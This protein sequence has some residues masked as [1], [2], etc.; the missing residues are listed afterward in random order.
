M[1][2]KAMGVVTNE[3]RRCGAGRAG[4]RR[5]AGVLLCVLGGATV[6]Q[7]PAASGAPDGTAVSTAR[8]TLAA[9]GGSEALERLRTLRFDFVV[10]RSGKEVARFRHVWDRKNGRYRVE[11]KTQE[12]KQL[13]VLFNLK[14]PSDG[15][16][17]LDRQ[18]L[19]GEER[20]DALERGY[21]RFIN[22]T[23]WLLMPTKMLDPGVR[24]VHEGTEEGPRGTFEIVRLSF[25][26]GVGLTPGDTYWA[27]VSKESGL[28]ERWDFVLQGKQAKDRATFFWQDWREVAGVRLS[29]TKRS[30]DGSTV[31]RFENVAGSA[32]REDAPFNPP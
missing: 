13:L 31:I 5:L 17:W 3:W 26:D 9:M 4:V 25:D 14:D 12:G 30:A 19:T 2:V 18:E 7:P 10:N 8:R 11:A 22:D 21:A 28:M 20:T 6:P 32:T 1:S 24:L 23:Y 27:Y 15:R 16:A 29:L